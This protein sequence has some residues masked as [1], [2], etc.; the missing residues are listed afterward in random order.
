MTLFTG[1]LDESLSVL[2]VYVGKSSDE[3]IAYAKAD[4]HTGWDEGRGAWPMGSLWTPEGKTLYALVTVFNAQNIVECGTWRGCS[5]THMAQALADKGSGHI[6]AIDLHESTG[7]L[8]PDN[9]RPY[10]S[11]QF[12]KGEDYLAL[13]P[14][15]S[16]DMLY[17]DTYHG[18]DCVRDIWSLALKKVKRGGV[19]VSHDAMHGQE[20][21]D[22]RGGI[23]DAG[24]TDYIAL[25]A[26]PSD[27]GLAVYVKP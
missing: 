2:A 6:T 15:N 11:Q 4:P 27:C 10:V 21:I 18:R 14:D 26:Q 5:T 22:V 12:M 8:I 20:G 13:L 9:L 1:G 7:D 3:F 24:V 19:I 23:E 25:L 16:I 17:E